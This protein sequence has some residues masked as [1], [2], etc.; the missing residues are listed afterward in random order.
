MDKKTD[1]LRTLAD[2]CY[3]LA[4]LMLL[5]A[6]VIAIIFV[7]CILSLYRSQ[8]HNADNGI[9]VMAGFAIMGVPLLLHF[10]VAVCMFFLGRNLAHRRNYATCRFWAILLC[11][12]I[13]IG[14]IL[15]ICV[16]VSTNKPYVRQ[17]FE[18]KRGPTKK[19][20]SA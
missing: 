7:G 4:G 15:G 2:W 9:A 14:T 5:I 12:F 18:S 10:L 8:P 3:A 13:P 20:A 6:G 1:K 16:L 17:L 19:G 11:F